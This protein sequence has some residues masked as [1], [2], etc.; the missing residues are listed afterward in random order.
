MR[1]RSIGFAVFVAIAFSVPVATGAVPASLKESGYYMSEPASRPTVQNFLN[2]FTSEGIFQSRTAYWTT[3]NNTSPG[4][5]AFDFVY[6]TGHGCPI[7][8]GKRGLYGITSYSGACINLLDAGNNS[9]HGYGARLKYLVL[10]SCETVPASTD[11]YD[12]ATKWLQEPGSIFD[13]LHTLMG[14]R[15]K[16]DQ[17][18][19]LNIAD[20]MGYLVNIDYPAILV[21]NWSNAVDTYG[22]S[23]D[24]YLDE[25]SMYTAYY[26]GHFY[27]AAYSSFWDVYGGSQ[28]Q[29]YLSPALYSMWS[30]AD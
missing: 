17:N 3:G 26:P 15:T 2:H 30:D 7:A 27:E 22:D 16:A 23:T 4:V 24:P 21:W 14:F 11:D 12:A 5:D 10:H 8:G 9:N 19:G 20:E 25:Y 1:T 6:Y 29:S 28:S 18:T 13:G